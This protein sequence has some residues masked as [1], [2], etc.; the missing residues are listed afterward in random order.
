MPHYAQF[1]PC[2]LLTAFP[3][4]DH[5]WNAKLQSN[6]REGPQAAAF[7]A[8]VSSATYLIHSDIKPTRLEQLFTSAKG[9][10][11]TSSAS[12]AREGTTAPVETAYS[13]QVFHFS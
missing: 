2:S 11:L 1:S 10:Y 3:W 4:E 6:S 7:S 12:F 9:Y 8:P 13:R 5:E